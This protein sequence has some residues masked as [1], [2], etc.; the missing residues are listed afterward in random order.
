MTHPTLDDDREP[1][2]DPAQLLLQARLRKL[3][4]VGYG[5]LALGFVAVFAA[6]VYRT[7]YRTAETP[8]TAWAQPMAGTLALPPGGRVVGTALDGDRMLVTVETPA[9]TTLLVVDATSL[10]QL[11]R[12]DL[13]QAP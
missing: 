2:L 11:R 9:G 13:Q 6:V 3:L 4:M 5:T 12:L 10:K 1:P 7:T 8:S